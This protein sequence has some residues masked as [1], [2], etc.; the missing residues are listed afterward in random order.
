MKLDEIQYVPNDN[1]T[2]YTQI[3]AYD[4]AEPLNSPKMVTYLVCS[5]E[6]AESVTEIK[7]NEDYSNKEE[8]YKKLETIFSNNIVVFFDRLFFYSFPSKL[9]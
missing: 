7:F 9:R 1:Y 3:I 5:K 8:V 6:F 2:S 4:L